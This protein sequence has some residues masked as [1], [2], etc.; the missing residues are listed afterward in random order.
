MLRSWRRHRGEDLP[1]GCLALEVREEAAEARE[2]KCGSTLCGCIFNACA[3][4]VKI[5]QCEIELNIGCGHEARLNL[6]RFH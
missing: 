4:D 1:D 3:E 5:I 2:K 6:C